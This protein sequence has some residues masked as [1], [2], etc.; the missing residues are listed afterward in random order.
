MISAIVRAQFLS[1]RSFR[2]GSSRRG[3]LLSMATGTIWYG[4]WT[5]VAIAAFQFTSSTTDEI[6]LRLNLPVGF[7]LVMLY[8]QFAPLVSASL[9]AS[10]DLK[11]LLVYPI[12]CG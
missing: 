1:M 6:A 2:L 12:P 7:L 4:I 5:L 10:L 3:A 11:K 8:W 9:G